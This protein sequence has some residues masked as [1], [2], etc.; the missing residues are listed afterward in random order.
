MKQNTGFLNP[1]FDQ[2]M[3]EI[4]LLCKPLADWFERNQEAMAYFE[5]IKPGC[6][7]FEGTHA[8][9]D[10][11]AL[12]R[13]A[14]AALMWLA[15]DSEEYTKEQKAFNAAFSIAQVYE[16]EKSKITD[17]AKDLYA[18]NT[19]KLKVRKKAIHHK[20]KTN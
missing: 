19:E 12:G 2:N 20:S 4:I 16:Q 7:H 18:I 17:V 10:V 3:E 13:M 9:H 11:V 5:F 15:S 1:S 6:L 8:N 14:N